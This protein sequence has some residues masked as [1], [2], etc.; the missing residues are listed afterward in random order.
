MKSFQLK[1]IIKEEIVI[2]KASLTEQ[3]IK[4]TVN[5]L[6]KTNKLYESILSSVLS[7]FLDSK[8]K[9]KADEF[10]DSPEY[11]ELIHQMEMSTKSLNYLTA[12]LKDKIDDYDKNISSMQKAGIKVKMGMSPKTMWKEYEKWVNATTKAS[13]KNILIK[14]N[15]EWDKILK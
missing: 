4:E 15:P 2:V 3:S 5:S 10:K 13:N 11:K 6:Y 7:I 1:Q 9:K 14:T 8:Y 12:K